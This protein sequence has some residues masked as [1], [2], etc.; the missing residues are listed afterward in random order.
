MNQTSAYMK[1]ILLLLAML[2]I[3]AVMA[4]PISPERAGKY[5][6]EKQQQLYPR[7][8]MGTTETIYSTQNEPLAYVYHL[9]PT[10]F[11]IIGAREELPPLYAYSGSSVFNNLQDD[12]P[13]ICLAKADLLARLNNPAEAATNR[14]AW[15]TTSRHDRI[16][17]WPPE[18]YSTTEGW[19][20][21]QWT[22]SYPYNMMCP[23]DSNTGNR[24]IAGCPAIAMGQILNYHQSINGTRLN[25]GDDY[26]HQYAGRNYWVDNDFATLDF[27]SFP[28]LNNYLDDLNH[29]YRYQEEVSDTL[30]AALV[31]ACGTALKQVYTSQGSGTFG[32]D[33]ALAAFHRF[34]FDEAELL[35]DSNPD[36]FTRMADN[37]MHG[38]PALLAVVTPNWQSGHNFVVDGYNE[39]NYFHVNFGWAGAYDGWILLPSQVPM[40]MTVV[41]GAVLDIK[42]IDYVLAVPD[43]IDF[44]QSYSQNLELYNLHTEAV[45]VEALLPGE[46]MNPADWTITPSQALPVTIPVNG[47]LSFQIN[48]IN[49]NLTVDV[50]GCLRLIMGDAVEDVPVQYHADSATEDL[51]QVCTALAVQSYPNPSKGEVNFILKTKDN[52]PAML[53]VFNIKGQRVFCQSVSSPG[54]ASRIQW[55]GMDTKGNKLARG[56]YLYRLHSGKESLS[57]KLIMLR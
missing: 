36:L 52:N 40:G 2:T 31:F 29:R 22:Q 32:V 37:I 55:N 54:T 7:L 1:F 34:G 41:E 26:H 39:N 43:I 44:S 35:T 12:N 11:M 25:D 48:L 21:T 45:V 42:P 3:S 46:G 24:G 15:Q 14:Q 27:P 57:G 9:Q 18:G 19:V 17:Q 33:Q 50:E 8:E 51:A 49:P 6:A 20:K 10:G 4:Q 38:Y 56:V 53:E 5:A 28:Q 13:L 47:M 23:M 16:Q 30:H